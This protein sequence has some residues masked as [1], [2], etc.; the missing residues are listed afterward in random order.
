[1]LSV[2]FMI[3]IPLEAIWPWS[4]LPW[5]LLEFC[6]FWASERENCWVGH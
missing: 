3:H 2:G 1:L 5:K 6:E 4:N